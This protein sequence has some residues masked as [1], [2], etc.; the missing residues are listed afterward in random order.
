MCPAPPRSAQK[1]GD[2]SR[3]GTN[4]NAGYKA[5]RCERPSGISA[6]PKTNL[7]TVDQRDL[8]S[9][10]VDANITRPAAKSTASSAAPNQF[11]STNGP[12]KSAGTF[13]RNQRP[14]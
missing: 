8:A 4:T 5:T 13:R 1:P 11:T 14:R 12:V 7:T 6:N 10:D 2:G 3:C 9:P